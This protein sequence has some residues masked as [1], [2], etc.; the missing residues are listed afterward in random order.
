MRTVIVVSL[1]LDDRPGRPNFHFRG[2]FAGAE[3]KALQLEPSIEDEWKKGE[4]Y[5]LYVRV[6]EVREGV[7]RGE[8][9]RSRPLVELVSLPSS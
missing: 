3:V 8:V 5:I 7:L 2:C 6:R 1:C 9:I 4:E